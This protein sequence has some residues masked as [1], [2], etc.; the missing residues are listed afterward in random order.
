MSLKIFYR[1][2]DNGKQSI[3]P[4]YVNWKSCFLNLLKN[5]DKKTITV[6]ADNIGEE[7]Y[8]FLKR[9]L[10]AP[11]I[12]RTSLGCSK[13]FI[14]TISKALQNSSL[15]DT[16]YIIDNEYIHCEGAKK[17]L[18]EGL[19]HADYVSLYDHLDKYMNPSPNPYVKNGGEVTKVIVS[20]STHWKFTN[21]TYLTFACKYRTLM[22]DRNTI[23]KHCVSQM[24]PDHVSLFVD[25]IQNKNRKLI[26]PIPGYATLGVTK[27]M[28]PFRN[29]EDIIGS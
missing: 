8:R 9:V 24:I 6:I 11:N 18:L 22:D 25:L 29:W 28:A 13:S 14:F 2:T 27:Y 17:V 7:T 1:L 10:D 3:K 5:F 23:I 19:H 21:S 4:D 15:E 26:T 12:I 20:K 16:V